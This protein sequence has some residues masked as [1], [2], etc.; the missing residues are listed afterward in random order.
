MGSDC[1]ESRLLFCAGKSNCAEFSRGEI[2]NLLG[3]KPE[4][5]CH[6]NHCGMKNAA[7]VGIRC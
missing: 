7:R 1:T 2:Y 4:G 3:H 6:H 5:G